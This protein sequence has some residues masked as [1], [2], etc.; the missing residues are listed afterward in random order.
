MPSS[1]TLR[2]KIESDLQHRYPAALTPA[3]RA[4]REVATTGIS[5]LDE[6]LDGGLPV[7][8]ISELTGPTSS[9]RT[10]IA[11]AFLASRTKDGSVCAWVDA[12]DA[13]DP[14]SAAA[15][16]IGLKHLLWVRCREAPYKQEPSSTNTLRNKSQPWIRL[17]QAIR[18]TDLLLQ[19]GGFA[20]IV[21]DLADEAIA[22]GRR[23]PLATWFRFRQAA[24]RIRC[25]LIVLGKA[26]YA[27]SSAALVVECRTDVVEPLSPKV[28]RGF[29]YGAQRGRERFTRV[30][31]LTCKPP[32]SAEWSSHAGWDLKK[33]DLEKRA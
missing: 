18:A 2:L 31:P 20:S 32:V 29:S 5:S 15:N 19:A 28:I 7:G 26:S 22:H 14:E 8:A 12:R 24:G 21:L 30:T 6:L 25:S 4:V 27:Q 23:I 11:L 17:D 16:G 33:P 3:P 10:N 13:F 9:G 1:T